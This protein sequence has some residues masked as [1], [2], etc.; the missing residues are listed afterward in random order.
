M[1]G[2]RRNAAYVSLAS[3]RPLLHTFAGMAKTI[4]AQS[5][6][7]A[8]HYGEHAWVVGVSMAIAVVLEAKMQYLTEC[9]PFQR[10]MNEFM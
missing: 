10:E 7:A 5:P 2:G 8:H 9:A 4:F 6:A 1:N 3:S